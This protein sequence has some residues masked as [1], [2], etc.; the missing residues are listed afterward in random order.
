M[1]S[2]IILY[3]FTHRELELLGEVVEYVTATEHFESTWTDEEQEIIAQAQSKLNPESQAEILEL[4]ER[5]L[6]VPTEGNQNDH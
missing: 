2:A 3:V 6:Q 5:F 1:A 4:E